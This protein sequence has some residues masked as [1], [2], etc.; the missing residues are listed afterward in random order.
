MEKGSRFDVNTMYHARYLSQRF[1]ELVET[2]SA[3]ARS[4]GFSLVEL[5]YAWIA[6]RPQVDS[7]L[8][9]PASVEQLDAAIAGCAKK[10]PEGLAAR[11][12]EVQRAFVGTDAVYAR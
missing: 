7:V 10:L 11:I 4:A 8:I 1:F 3:L 9:G 12:D 6:Q 2:Y 5:A